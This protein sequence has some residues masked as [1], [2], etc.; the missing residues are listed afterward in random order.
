M[1][2]LLLVSA[3]V[4]ATSVSFAQQGVK[5]DGNTVST[6]EIAPVWPGCEKSELSSKDCFNKMMNLHI[7]EQFKYPKD[8]KGNFIR[9]K[10][11]LAFTIDEKGG[12]TKVTAEG[13]QKAINEEVVRIVKAFPKMQPGIRGGTE[14]P[15]KYKMVFNF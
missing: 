5:V 4:L 9:G 13:P 2:N 10:T 3:F 11:T 15:V 7:K 12:V 6:K 1:K 8:A 14:I